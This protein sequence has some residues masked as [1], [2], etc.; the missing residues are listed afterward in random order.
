MLSSPAV[1][2]GN[3]VLAVEMVAV[4]FSDSS[5]TLSCTIVIFTEAEVLPGGNVTEYGPAW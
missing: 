4:K 2:L 5:K 3:P 1:I